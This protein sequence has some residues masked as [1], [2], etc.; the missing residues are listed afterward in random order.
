MLWFSKIKNEENVWNFDTVIVIEESV[1]HFLNSIFILFIISLEILLLVLYYTL[2]LYR[3]KLLPENKR[4]ALL[5]YVC[6]GN[7]S[8]FVHSA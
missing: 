3:K 5:S 8:Y 1:L 4:E 6:Q 7:Y 2:S